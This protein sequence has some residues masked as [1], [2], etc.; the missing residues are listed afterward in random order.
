MTAHCRRF[1]KRFIHSASAVAVFGALSAQAA[2]LGHSRVASLP[3]QPLRITVLIK[4]LS[5]SERQSLSAHIAPAAAWKEAGL[6]PP[7][8]LSS[9]STQLQ[10]GLNPQQLQL[11]VSSTEKVDA[12]VVDVLVDIQSTASTQR[13]QVSVLQAQHVTPIALAAS[14]T[15]VTAAPLTTDSAVVP[16]A[17]PTTETTWKVQSGQHLYAIARQLK[18]D[19]YND[20]QLMAALIQTNPQAFI[21][22]N[23]NLL[24]AGATLQIPDAATIA[25]ISPQQARQLYQKHVQWFDEY[26][27]RLAKGEAI[28][29]MGQTQPATAPVASDLNAGADRLELSTQT[30]AEQK[31][32]Q[33]LATAQ[34]LAYSAERLAQLEKNTLASSATDPATT[35]ADSNLLINS[36]N[37]AA[38][39]ALAT[40]IAASASAAAQGSSDGVS[41][42]TT[43]VSSSWIKAH[44][45]KLG[46][47]ILVFLVLLVTWLLRRVQNSR[48][49][50]A[51]IVPDSTDR[52]REK[53]EKI[54]LD[55]NS[56]M[57]DEVEFR[58]IK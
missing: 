20:Q 29:P 22:G 16:L 21:H 32:D 23:M 44:S 13:H 57:T 6:T 54:N 56:P 1:I 38:E 18:N 14:K 25:A 15:V 50:Y 27:Q 11:V 12:K 46:L 28:V 5:P 4:D 47:G 3:D 48:M 53:L 45:I 35:L 58:E 51:E 41:D 9:L 7:A 49:D 43:T 37:T 36:E 33:A 10:P 34:E 30:E 42:A 39:T 24:R 17:T 8:A 2:T 31:A 40:N 52:V 26:R 55:L 19:Q